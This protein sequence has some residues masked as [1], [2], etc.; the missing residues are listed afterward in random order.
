MMSVRRIRLSSHVLNSFL[1]DSELW[2][3]SLPADVNVVGIAG[4][5]RE[6]FVLVVESN[7][8]PAIPEGEL[9]PFVEPVFAR[10]RYPA[11]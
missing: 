8:F 4:E 1:R 9:I 5:D 6:A 2:E 10:K 3:S 11:P 7:S